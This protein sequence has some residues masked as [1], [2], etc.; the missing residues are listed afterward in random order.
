VAVSGLK[1]KAV[2]PTPNLYVSIA[3]GR[4]KA[5]VGAL[6]VDVAVPSIGVDVSD[7]SIYINATVT[8]VKIQDRGPGRSNLDLDAPV[9]DAEP[10]V[11]KPN[12]YVYGIPCLSVLDLYAII[13]DAP[14]AGSDGRLDL[15]VISGIDSDVGIRAIDVKIS[16]AI[17][18]IG[19]GPMIRIGQCRNCR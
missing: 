7:D 4:A 16:L 10:M 15:T 11:G 13:A 8:C 3:G 17:D 12:L 9:P 19:P 5:A 18:L 6:D 1:V 2:E 14:S